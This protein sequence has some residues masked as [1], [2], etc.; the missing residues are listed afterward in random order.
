LE[1]LGERPQRILSSPL[2][3]ARQ[4]ADIVA[5]VIGV[6][7]EIRDELAPSEAAPNIVRELTETELDRLLVVG[8]AP[9]V[10]ILVADLVE[11]GGHAPGFEP[12]MVVAIDIDANR[13]GTEA[14]V[15][16]PSVLEAG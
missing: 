1:R 10:S 8:H 4:T 14:F 7:V 3:R 12:G 15:L 13:N 16:R 2:T 11:A 9:D 6:A 5:R